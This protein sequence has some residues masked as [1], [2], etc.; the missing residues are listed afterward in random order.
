MQTTT[1]DTKI[2]RN[3]PPRIQATADKLWREGND[4]G[5][6]FNPECDDEL[7]R[8]GFCEHDTSVT[9]VRKGKD[10]LAVGWCHGA[11][12]VSVTGKIELD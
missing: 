9:L 7:E 11:W 6:G 2:I 12:A 8:S 3:V 5:E 10:L 4:N 1:T